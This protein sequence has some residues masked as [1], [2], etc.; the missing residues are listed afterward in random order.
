M[1]ASKENSGWDALA[2]LERGNFLDDSRIFE[3][4]TVILKEVSYQGFMIIV[5]QLVINDPVP[6][7]SMCIISIMKCYFAR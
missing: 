6:I 1:K 4:L 2:K 3:I 7:I 5:G